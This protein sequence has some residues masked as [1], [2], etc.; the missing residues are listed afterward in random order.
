MVASLNEGVIAW[1][2]VS[3]YLPPMAPLAST[4]VDSS[5]GFPPFERTVFPV[6]EIP[7]WGA[8]HSAAEWDRHYKEMDKSD[9]V[10]LPRYDLKALAMPMDSLTH[11]FTERSVPF[12][13]AKLAYSTRYYGAYDLDAGE[14]SGAHPG[15]DLKLAFGTPIG[16]IAG[17]RVHTV[18]KDE[19][20][21]LYVMIEHRVPGGETY[22]SIYG[23]L[24][25]VW[26]QEGEG[27]R[28]GQ[29]IGTVGMTGN[30]TAPHVHLQVDRDTGASP[31]VRFWPGHVLTAEGADR[32]TVNP[33]T[34]IEEHAEGLE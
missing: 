33:I 13:T 2:L 20:M 4:L 10:P 1:N 14:Y 11:P 25:V 26:V 9:F 6:V 21:G 23:H 19:N 34:F 31:H 22:Y 12:I 24:D 16:A 27:V 15:I 7:N 17:G 5:M 32:Y 18:A 28:P 30:T 29:S 8:M 3:P